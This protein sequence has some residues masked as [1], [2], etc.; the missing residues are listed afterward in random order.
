MIIF[1][2]DYLRHK[3]K[4]LYFLKKFMPK[5]KNNRYS[6]IDLMKKIGGIAI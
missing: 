4:V 2:E 3:I 1:N 5:G 6:K